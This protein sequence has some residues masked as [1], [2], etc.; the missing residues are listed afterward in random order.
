MN[1][2]TLNIRIIKRANVI[3]VELDEVSGIRIREHEC[4]DKSDC[5]SSY[6]NRPAVFAEITVAAVH[7]S[8]RY[9][10]YV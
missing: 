1:N 8:T 9:D 4:H 10:R 6:L 7:H 3:S 2:L 5:R